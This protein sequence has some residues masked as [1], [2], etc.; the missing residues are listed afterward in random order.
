VSWSDASGNRWL[1]GGYG[2]DSTGTY[3]YLN[4]LW[5]FDPKLG[6]HGE[7]TWMTGSNAAN[8]SG[9]YDALGTAGG[10]LGARLGAMSWSDASGNLWLFGGYGY[11]MWG[12]VNSTGRLGWLNDLWKLDPLSGGW[13]WMSGSAAVNQSA[14]Y[15]TLGTAASTNIPGARQ[16]AV[17]WNDASGNLWLFGGYG[18]NATGTYGYGYL[19]DLWKFDPK[20]GTYGTWT[21]MGGTSAIGQSGVY[22]TLG[23]A[24]STN[25][26]G[27]RGHAVSWSDAS[28]NLWL[29]G[30]AV[31][32]TGVVGFFND[33]WKFDPTLGTYGAW[34]WMSG[35]NAGNQSAVY[36]TL[37][38]AAST[39]IPGARDSAV[40]W[41]DASGKL[42]LFGGYGYDS[43]GAYGYLNDLWK[44]DPTLGTY[45]EWTWMGGSKTANQ[46][47][48]YGPGG[49]SDAM[50]WSDASG[51]LWLFGGIVESTEANG[52][53]NDLWEYQP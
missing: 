42:W 37:G 26:P 30:G 15:G 31:D 10:W 45:G 25:L 7:W 33:L 50:S 16:S 27:A 6:A 12:T 49:R 43:T 20:L 34:T 3:G 40:S 14:V 47:G 1:F 35:S 41:S 44:F 51:N 19:N 52:Y 13:T 11:D 48:V 21:W 53:I 32:S 29:F 39:N 17:S 5:E 38:T 18:F 28:G 2:L 4:D 24:A 36:G 9:D 8:E 23:T 46:S 22:G